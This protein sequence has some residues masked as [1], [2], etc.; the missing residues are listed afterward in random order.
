MKRILVPGHGFLNSADQR[1]I[2]AFARNG[3]TRRDVLRGLVAAGIG[4]GV[5]GTVLSSVTRAYAETPKKGGT[6]R[7][8]GGVSSNADTLDPAVFG[9]STDYSRGFMFYNGLTTLDSKLA[10]QPGL[11]SSWDHDG[12][13]KVWTFKLR[14]DVRFHDGKGFSAQD[15]VYSLLRHKDPNVG[16]KA[17]V[18]SGQIESARAASPTELEITLVAGNADLPVLLGTPHFLIIQDGQTDFAKPVGTGPYKVEEFTPG[19]RSLAVRNEDYW[20]DGQPYL[21]AIEF[22]GL[23]EENAR[24][25][26]LLS[27]DVQ[28]TTTINPRSIPQ[29]EA[30]PDMRLFETKG[31]TYTDMIMRQDSQ[32]TGNADFVLGMKYLMNRQLVRN[33]VF[34]E[35]AVIANDHPIDPTNPFFAADLPQR[36]YDPEKAKFHFEK[37]GVLGT[38]IPMVVSET[39]RASIEIGTIMQQDAADLGLNIELQRVPIDGYW[40]NYWMKVPLGFGTLTPRP[41]ADM[42][43]SLLYKSDAAWNEAGWK[44]EKFDQL[45]LA[46]RVEADFDKRRQMY[47]DMQY[48]I[49]EFGGT[50]IPTFYSNLDAHHAS[51]KGLVPIPTGNMMGY[52]FAEHVWLEA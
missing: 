16:S 29:L 35:Y 37:A 36:P 45:L 34:R 52:N 12:T 19:V 8:A 42:M 25:N 22:F 5:A 46:A 3:A 11:A 41:T 10:A 24:L 2:M 1:E 28:L 38:T 9:N 49:H 17:N 48:L 26:A 51:L 18:I 40:S 30:N 33:S 32:P 7:V 21:D 23:S 31:G 27:G 50:A 39:A 44:N 47:A 15:A 20:K 4:A 6:L 43:L 13:S 14:D